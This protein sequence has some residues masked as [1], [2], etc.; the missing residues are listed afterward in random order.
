MKKWKEDLLLISSQ[1]T[2]TEPHNNNNNNNHNHNHNNITFIVVG[3]KID[4]TE[5]QRKV[6]TQ[7]A[8]LWC[9]ENGEMLYIETS[10]LWGVNV[11][12][13]FTRVTTRTLEETE[14]SVVVE[15]QQTTLPDAKTT[16]TSCCY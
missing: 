11:E 10:A 9:Q 12:E 2:S 14:N 13:A 7:D 5:E 1:S 3:N 6:S 4:I 15:I 16:T 8:Q